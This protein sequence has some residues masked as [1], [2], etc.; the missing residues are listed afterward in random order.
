MGQP[1]RLLRQL[2]HQLGL[3][4]RRWVSTNW[5]P[6]TNVSLS[7]NCQRGGVH[8][9]GGRGGKKQED[10]TMPRTLVIQATAL[11][12]AALS[13]VLSPLA[14]SSQSTD[15]KYCQALL[16]KYDTFIVKASGHAPRRGDNA[17]E[18][19]ASK[20]REG[21]PA[22][23]RGLERALQDAKIDLPPRM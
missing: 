1:L 9:V 17:A 23:I 13:I 8:L 11:L 14:A 16:I 10:P 6:S 2:D 7:A 4:G 3:A 5:E 12:M 19:A 20:C 22:G 15:G 21:D 18:V